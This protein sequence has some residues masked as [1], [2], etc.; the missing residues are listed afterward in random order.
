MSSTTS[1]KYSQYRSP[2]RKREKGTEHLL[3][4]VRTEQFYPR[5][6]NRYPTQEAHRAPKKMKAKRSAS[7]Q[8]IIEMSK[9]KE[10]EKNLKAAKEKQ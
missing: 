2:R 9:I 7:R 10:K 4:D 8:I 6:G 1:N 5:E 3:E